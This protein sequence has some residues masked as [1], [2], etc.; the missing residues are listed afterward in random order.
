MTWASTP[1]PDGD[2]FDGTDC[3]CDEFPNLVY[4]SRSLCRPKRLEEGGY[5]NYSF[6]LSKSVSRFQATPPGIRMMDGSTS[7]T[8]SLRRLGVVPFA[9]T[10]PPPP[11]VGRAPCGVGP[12][13]AI[14]APSTPFISTASISPPSSVVPVS[15]RVA[16]PPLMP[17]PTVPSVPV[18]DAR[19]YLCR[20]LDP[21][22]CKITCK[23]VCHRCGVCTW[24]KGGFNKCECA[25]TKSGTG[26]GSDRAA[27]SVSPSLS[28]TSST[29][30]A[31]TTLLNASWNATPAVV[32]SS[33]SG[34]AVPIAPAPPV[35]TTNAQVSMSTSSTS[36]NSGSAPKYQCVGLAG[37]GLII[38][39]SLSAPPP[40]SAQ[41]VGCGKTAAS[42]STNN[43][44]A[45]PSMCAIPALTASIT[46]ISGRDECGAK[47]CYPITYVA[48]KGESCV[49]C[50]AALYQC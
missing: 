9:K 33:N 6:S 10:A 40:S 19:C 41:V 32:W 3:F 44:G 26:V 2:G 17:I 15:A 7:P 49:E 21:A 16:V 47:M 43:S 27:V 20:N 31:T 5:L 24:F 48:S 12:S 39:A 29:T 36:S 28:T 38:R 22:G 45:T 13:S 42:T 25:A 8:V 14:K 18:A 1:P 23:C 30:T 50:N 35:T 46:L 34:G 4:H 11:P 37:S